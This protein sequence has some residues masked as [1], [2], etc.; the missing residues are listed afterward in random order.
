MA[1]IVHIK[2][3]RFRGIRLLEWIPSRRVN[4][5]IGPGDSCKTTILDAIELALTPRSYLIADDSDFFDLDVEKAAKI[6][7]TL[8][9][10]PAE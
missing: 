6:T 8:A 7:V 2:I 5:L 10:L 4:C 9:G 3:E 1:R